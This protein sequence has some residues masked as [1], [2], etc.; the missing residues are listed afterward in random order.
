MS[1]PVPQ[2]TMP[3]VKPT[4]PDHMRFAILGTVFLGNPV[5][6]VAIRYATQARRLAAEGNYQEAL[7]ISEKARKWCWITLIS[8]IIAV[9]IVLTILVIVLL[10]LL[11]TI[12]VL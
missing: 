7:E 9:I 10:N 3:D 5:G 8:G 4:I 1:Q 6:F 12:G 11:K 2:Q